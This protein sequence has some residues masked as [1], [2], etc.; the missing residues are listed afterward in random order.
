MKLAPMLF[1]KGTGRYGAVISVVVV[2]LLPLS[3]P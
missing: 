2:V 1:V 3:S